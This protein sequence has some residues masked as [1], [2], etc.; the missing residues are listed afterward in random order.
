[1]SALIQATTAAAHS[2]GV[3]HLKCA[4]ILLIVRGYVD[5]NVLPRPQTKYHA[6]NTEDI[7]LIIAYHDISSNS[8]QEELFSEEYSKI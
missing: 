2:V 1:M 8:N 6:V 5:V 7:Q 4:H 3:L